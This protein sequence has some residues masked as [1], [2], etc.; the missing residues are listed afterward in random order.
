MP[1]GTRSVAKKR[2]DLVPASL[3]GS[4][5]YFALFVYFAMFFM[6]RDVIEATVHIASIRSLPFFISRSLAKQKLRSNTESCIDRS[7]TI[8]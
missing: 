2:G 1:V 8:C 4:C 7:I 5:V 6:L 3:S